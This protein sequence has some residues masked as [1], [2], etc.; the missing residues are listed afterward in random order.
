MATLEKILSEIKELKNLIAKLIGTSD[1]GP[2]EQFSKEA[3]DKAA[4]EYQ[5]LSIERGEWVTGY[6]MDKCIKNAPYGAG[7]FII[8]E[9]GFSNYFMRGKQ[10]YFNKKDLTTLGKELKERHID[11]RRYMELKQDQKMFEKYIATILENKTGKSKRKS[12]KIPLDLVDISTTPPKMP[13]PEVLKSELEILKNDFF[14]NKMGEYI[15]IYKGNYAMIKRIYWIQ[16]YIDPV[17]KR[18][19][20]KWIDEFNLVNRLIEEVT[21]KKENFIPIPESEM[22][23]L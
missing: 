13:S 2:I 22:I 6:D 8:E 15:D 7:K 23:Q 11:L 3:L 12:F 20:K 10:H 19:L 5:K 16:K 14:E 17:I 4:K 21:K 18:R 9:F 1:L